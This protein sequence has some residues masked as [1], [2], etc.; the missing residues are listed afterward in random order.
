[1]SHL[2]IDFIHD[3]RWQAIPV[4]VQTMARRCLL[5]LLGVAASGTRTELSRVVSLHALQ[6]FGPGNSARG[7][8]LLF[9]GRVC[10]AAG[11]ALA[12]GMT[13]DSIDAHDGYKPS[14]GHAGCGVVAALLALHD[15]EFGNTEDTEQALLTSLVI[16]YEMACR[17]GVALHDSTPDY[18]TSGAW[19]ALAAAAL[20]AR[21]LKLNTEQ[22]RHALGIAEYHGP[23]SQM[24]RCIDHPTMLKDGSGWGAMAG[25]SAAYLA[26]NGFTG[27]PA[28]TVETE[29]QWYTDLGSRWLVTEQYFKPYPVC[30]WA[31]PAMVAALRLQHENP[32]E[33]A[34]VESLVIG[35]F[36]ESKR[37]ST[38]NPTTTEQAQY[39][40][41][42]PVA[43]AL[44]N[45]NL[46]VAEI[47]DGALQDA[48]VTTLSQSIVLQ[49]VQQ[50]N[51]EFPQRRI[52]DVTITLK[53]G[54][55]LQSGPT[56]ADGDPE[57]PM[58]ETEIVKKFHT[59]ASP[60]VGDDTSQKLA[61]KILGM[62]HTDQTL[63]DFFS[64]IF[65]AMD[66]Q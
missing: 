10:S 25:V 65:P 66:N 47:T 26:Q 54:R 8:R 56:E 33:I 2:C 17:A 21:V 5:D 57:S 22:S 55:V 37:L 61:T 35:T 16:G 52:S 13:I 43:T 4:E 42:F 45:K 40:L 48:A 44:A 64:L 58:S 20:G 62:G 60:A 23:R 51:D 15:S 3:M 59:F 27:A 38:A 53:D 63:E 29:N 31:Q 32:F 34:E 6:Q 19:V 50:Y 46:T 18:H 41:P 9:D 11:A 49:E 14:K 30:R 36:H 1:M 39:S 7:A 28:L 24:M 12:N